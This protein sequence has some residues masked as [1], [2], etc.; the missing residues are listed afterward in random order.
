MGI[1]RDCP[2]ANDIKEC[3]RGV[4]E[5]VIVSRRLQD[6]VVDLHGLCGQ[7][8]SWAHRERLEGGGFKK[9]SQG[10]CAEAMY[11]G[12]NALYDGDIEDMG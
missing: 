7:R 12:L 8:W 6:F 3:G 11:E 4:V 1:G 5:D 10:G 9:G 2:L